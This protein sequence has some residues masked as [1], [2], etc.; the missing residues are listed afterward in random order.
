M[1][2]MLPPSRG[3]AAAPMCAARTAVSC[4]RDGTAIS[5]THL[6][7]RGTITAPGGG[8]NC[9][10]AWKADELNAAWRSRFLPTELMLAGREAG[11]R[12]SDAPRQSDNQEA[13][14]TTLPC[15]TPQGDNKNL[16]TRSFVWS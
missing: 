12:S 6:P 9:G 5:K 3:A 4:R 14:I 13:L 8:T 2:P 15:T 11:H 1:H 7:D 16:E 10:P